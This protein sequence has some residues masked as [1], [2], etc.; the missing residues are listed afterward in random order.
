MTSIKLKEI[1]K[2]FLTLCAAGNSREAFKLYAHGNF[3]HHNA[4]FKGDASSLMIAMEESSK[5]NPN[6]VF[7]IKHILMDGDLVAYHSYLKQTQSDAGLAVVHILKFSDNK[8]IE[9]WDMHQP[10]PEN[11]V[12]ENGM[13]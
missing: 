2:D 11:M 1:G 8:I 12:N 7:D 13:F 6:R 4:F 3:K 10:I 9:M 5:E